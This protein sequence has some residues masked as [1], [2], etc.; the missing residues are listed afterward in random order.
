MSSCPVFPCNSLSLS[1]CDSASG[2]FP[3]ITLLPLKYQQLPSYDTMLVLN[4]SLQDG[5]LV[6]VGFIVEMWLGLIVLL[7]CSVI[8]TRWFYALLDRFHLF[9]Q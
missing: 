6:M 8:C 1:V 7:L 5:E 9:T 2:S 4:T 3:G